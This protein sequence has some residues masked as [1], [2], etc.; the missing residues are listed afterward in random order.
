MLR[1]RELVLAGMFAALLAVGALVSIPIGPVPFT[2]QVFVV[3]LAAMVLGPRLAILAVAGY[4]VLGL[5]APVFS[6]GA[7]GVAVL[8]GPTAG[9]LWGFLPAVLVTGAL[10]RRAR[11]LPGVF[12]AGAAGLVPVYALGVLW[13]WA[14]LDTASVH[15]VLVGGVLQFL[16]LDLMKAAL[17]A[18][19][20][21]SL[22]SLPLGLP[23][24]GR[25]R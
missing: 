7:S 14:S 8:V 16:P 11:S 22:V 4:L 10:A 25:G 12:V 13:L 21:G 19:V 6:G 9:Y 3:L 20:A 23:A 2:L 1:T 17:A 15:V 5:V 18:A 24:I